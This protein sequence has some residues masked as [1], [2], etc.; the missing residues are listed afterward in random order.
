M[1][2]P[3]QSRGGNVAHG[4]LVPC[5]GQGSSSGGQVVRQQVRLRTSTQFFDPGW[6]RLATDKPKPSNLRQHSGH[7]QLMT[8]P[9]A[10]R[11]FSY[12]G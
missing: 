1:A 6:K 8:L 3:C 2:E 9:S 10:T 11:F 5:C 4:P 12:A 7:A